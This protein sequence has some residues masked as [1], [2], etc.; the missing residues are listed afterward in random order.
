MEVFKMRFDNNNFNFK[1]R[2]YQ[3]LRFVTSNLGRSY[4]ENETVNFSSSVKRCRARGKLEILISCSLSREKGTFTGKHSP[5][6]VQ[7]EQ[8]DPVRETLRRILWPMRPDYWL[9]LSTRNRDQHPVTEVTARD[10]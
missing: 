9:M 8:L 1:S 5:A 4:V 3:S 7:P 10:M 2:Q 6:T